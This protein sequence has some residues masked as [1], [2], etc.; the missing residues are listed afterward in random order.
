MMVEERTR[1][2]AATNARLRAE[3]DAREQAQTA[4]AQAQKMEAVGQLTGGVAHDFNNLLTAVSTS[5]ELLADLG[6]KKFASASY[7]A[8]WRSPRS[9]AHAIAARLRA[10]AASGAGIG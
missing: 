9:E 4:L 10:Q 5:L 6:R 8:T 7:R 3:I 1:E 2:L